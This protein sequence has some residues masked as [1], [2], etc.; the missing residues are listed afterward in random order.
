MKLSN[1]VDEMGEK[2]LGVNI[3]TGEAVK[4]PTENKS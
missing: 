2:I 3:L 4:A 1:M